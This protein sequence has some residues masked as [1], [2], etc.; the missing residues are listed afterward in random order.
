MKGD[1]THS[2]S[3]L[4]LDEKNLI[5]DWRDERMKKVKAMFSLKKLVLVSALC[6]MMSSSMVF[7][8]VINTQ[9]LEIKSNAGWSGINFYNWNTVYSS[10]IGFWMANAYKEQA[11]YIATKKVGEYTWPIRFCIGDN[12]IMD[13]RPNGN[14]GIG[15]GT[16][17][18]TEKLHVVGNIL[19]TGTITTP[20]LISAGSYTCTSDSRYK[21]NITPIGNALARIMNLDGVYYNWKASEFKDM[22]FS[23]ERQ[24][25]FVAQDVEKVFPELV[26]TDKDGYK[27]MS[28][29]KM[30]AVLVEAVKEMNRKTVA[31][32][33]ENRELRIEIASMKKLSGRIAALESRLGAVAMK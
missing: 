13:M 25:G 2:L 27:S 4:C 32:E 8:E 9:T 12:T 1:K 31:L 6:L 20:G 26:H 11:L 33:K 30:T 19:A 28:Y 22:N 14:V 24:I 16:G 21:K 3:Y 18:P 17:D 23:K 10:L 29:D 5:K 15:T 7:G